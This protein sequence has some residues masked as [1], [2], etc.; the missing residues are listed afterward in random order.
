MNDGKCDHSGRFWSGTLAL[1]EQ[2][3]VGALYRLDPSGEVTKVLSGVTV[4][5][6]LGWSPDQRTFYYIDSRTQ[7]VDAFSHDPESGRIARRRLLV[8]I[9]SREGT[10]DGLTVDVE[11]HLWV[12]LW[13]GSVVRRYTPQGKQEYEVR[14]PA[15]R[16]TS[17]AFGGD[18][19]A[20]LYVTSATTG[21]APSDLRSQP[22]AGAV[23][24]IRPGMRGLPTDT[25]A[26]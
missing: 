11:G 2:R 9:P 6:G 18:D 10:P 14:L 19:L 26:G 3:P 7:R 15:S 5:N 4:S 20:D 12:A 16:V 17:C 24:V 23:F 1:D 25:F 13:D 8:A 21:L 22:H